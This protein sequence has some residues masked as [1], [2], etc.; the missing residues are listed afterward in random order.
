M[1]YNNKPMKYLACIVF[2]CVLQLSPVV[3]G[4]ANDWPSGSAQ[5]PTQLDEIVVTADRE[6]G[7]GTPSKTDTAQQVVAKLVTAGS[8]YAVIFLV[9]L[10][11]L[12]FMYGMMKYMF[13]GSGSDTAR[14]EG[15]K[16]MLWGL[17]GLFVM[18]SVWGL[19]GILANTIGHKSTALPQFESEGVLAPNG[20][21]PDGTP[22]TTEQV[23]ETQG[24][25]ERRQQRIQN[26]LNRANGVIQNG[27]QN[28]NNFGNAIGNRF[29]Q[30]FGRGQ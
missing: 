27:R 8:N 14:A 4:A 1:M 9:G 6:P 2:A 19:V 25:Q 30:W 24:R 18:V 29:N 10:T 22:V 7:P 23:N 26:W 13:K 11:L 17:I 12:V 15:R 3:A 16:L 20:R 21:N 28:L 5:N